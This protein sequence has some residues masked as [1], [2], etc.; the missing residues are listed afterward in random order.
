M[1]TAIT[2]AA[3][4]LGLGR[5]LT[6]R[7]LPLLFWETAVVLSVLP[8]ID[9][10]AFNVGIP[11]DHP[12]GHR[13]F[14]HSLCFAVVVA[15]GAALLTFR[16]FAMRWWSLWIF[17]FVVTASHGVLDAFT[18]H[19]LGR[20]I[21]FFSPFDLTRYYFPWTPIECPPIGI[22]AFFS[23]RG[24]DVIL[25]E[26]VWVWLPTGV[27]VAVVELSRVWFQRGLQR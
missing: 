21:A 14:T 2:H 23:E 15:I 1:C 9:V 22:Q 26:L 24:L 11:Y 13:G 12:L 6:A 20:G 7:R 18:D 10:L 25:S 17:F 19:R 16:R 3:V 27:I 4:A 8:D 5:V